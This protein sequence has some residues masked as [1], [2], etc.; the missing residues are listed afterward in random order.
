MNRLFYFLSNPSSRG[1]PVRL[2]Y[3]CWCTYGL[4]IIQSLIYIRYLMVCF[5]IFFWM[6]FILFWDRT[7]VKKKI[8]FSRLL[9][10]LLFILLYVNDF[11]RR[12]TGNDPPQKVINSVV[13]PVLFFWLRLQVPFFTSSN[14]ASSS[15]LYK[16]SR[17]Y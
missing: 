9:V 13:G 2:A 7:R 14:S 5:I 12:K 3:L 4:E 8:F 6:N 1:Q 16:I 11:V 15:F 17:K 10:L